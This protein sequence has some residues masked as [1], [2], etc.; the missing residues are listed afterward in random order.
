MLASLINLL[1]HPL[2]QILLLISLC[3]HAQL[4]ACCPASRSRADWVLAASVL[5]FFTNILFCSVTD[6][7]SPLRPY[8][9]DLY[10][11]ALDRCLGSPAFLIGRLVHASPV[12]F[13]TV[14]A[15][16]A[17]LPIALLVSFWATVTFRPVETRFAA[18]TLSLNAFLLP[19]CYLLVPI[20]G[21]VYAFPSFPVLPVGLV[22]WA[23]IPL[24][25][26][27]NGMPSGH[28]AGALLICWFTRHW[29]AGR[30]AS[31]VFLVLTTLAT[32]GLGEHYLIDLIAAIPYTVTILWLGSAVKLLEM[33]FLTTLAS[34]KLGNLAPPA[35]QA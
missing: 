29:L 25:A 14:S 12:L 34:K 6:S 10:A 30:V 17:L 16:Y 21:P 26:A 32:L 23:A 31:S 15:A 9:L 3:L 4:R 2:A 18:L 28:F 27:P 19:L 11:F 8:K 35:M 33:K 24:T 13:L 5:A 7:L 1:I 22:D 20:S